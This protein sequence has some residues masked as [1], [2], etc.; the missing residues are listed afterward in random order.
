MPKTTQ[1]AARTEIVSASCKMCSYYLEL[2]SLDLHPPFEDMYIFDVCNRTYHLQCLLKT[3]CYN[4]NEREAIDTNDT[5]ACV[6]L[7]KN[8]KR[9]DH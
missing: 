4:A 8:E 7:N 2:E 6:N 1:A 5:W 3:N 9:K